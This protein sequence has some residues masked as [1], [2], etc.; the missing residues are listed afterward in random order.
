MKRK[1]VKKKEDGSSGKT[2][3]NSDRERETHA[4]KLNRKK[5][6][7]RGHEK[8]GTEANYLTNVQLV[9]ILMA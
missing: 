6:F 3:G 2:F 4:H 5:K 1:I 8:V 7:H 9:V